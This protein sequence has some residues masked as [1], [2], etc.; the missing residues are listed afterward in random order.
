MIMAVFDNVIEDVA[1]R[2]GLGGKAGPLLHEVVQLM[3]SSPGGIG[4]FIEKFRS[5]GLGAEVGSWLGKTDGTTLTGPQVEKAL[6]NT[7]IDGA[8][9]RLGPRGGGGA[10]AGG[11]L[12]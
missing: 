8:A 6:G 1:G 4:G 3:T 2:F 7:V 10:P 11:G 12:P 9:G 5:A